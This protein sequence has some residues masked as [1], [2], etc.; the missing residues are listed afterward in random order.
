MLIS[1][2]LANIIEWNFHNLVLTICDFNQNHELL[3][4]STRFGSAKSRFCFYV[5]FY[6]LRCVTLFP[7]HCKISY[8][9]TWF[10]FLTLDGFLVNLGQQLS[11]RYDSRWSKHLLDVARPTV[12]KQNYLTYNNFFFL[13]QNVNLVWNVTKPLADIFYSLFL[14][15]SLFYS[16]RG[17][18]YCWNFGN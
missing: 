16:R 6:V 1:Q 9:L 10:N 17:V 8:Y 7:H 12:S 2:S 3:N 5:M 14:N 15:V 13:K 4:L 18:P 11:L